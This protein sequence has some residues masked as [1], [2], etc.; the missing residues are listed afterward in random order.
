MRVELADMRVV[1]LANVGVGLA[2]GRGEFGEQADRAARV[3]WAWWTCVRMGVRAH[4]V[5]G[6]MR[7][8][9]RTGA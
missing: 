6:L 3:L 2:E 7:G 1:G 5:G 8:A 4:G 9:W